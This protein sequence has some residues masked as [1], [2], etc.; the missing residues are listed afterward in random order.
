M[1][2]HS[3][4]IGLLISSVSLLA[5]VSL[6]PAWGRLGHDD[7]PWKRPAPPGRSPELWAFM[8]EYLEAVLERSPGTGLQFG[9]ERYNDRLF[10]ASPEALAAWNARVDGFLARLEGMDR[11]GFSEADRVD[12][13]LHLYEWR[14]GVK[15]RRFHD[16]QMPVSSIDGPHFSLPQM[17]LMLPFRTPKHFADYVSRLEH[18]AGH[19]D[20]QVTQMRL[21]MSAGRTQPRFIVEKSLPVARSLA[22]CPDPRA[23]PFY[24]P[25][26]GRDEDELAVRARSVI[27]DSIT[28]AFARFAGFLEREYAPACRESI[29]AGDGVDG[30]A[31]YD[32]RLRVQ[33]TTDLTAD[34]VHAI[35]LAEVARLRGEMLAVIARTDFPGRDSLSGDELFRAFVESLRTDRRF[36][37][38]TPGALLAHYR[39]ISKRIDGELPK[40]FGVL[41]RNPYGVRE[42]PR[43]AAPT[44]PTAYY[45][46]GSLKSGVAGFFM[47]NTF[48]LDQR[49]MYEAIALTLHEAVPGHHLQTALAQEMEGEHPLR[50]LGGYTA[51]VEGWALYAE[52]LGLEV[53]DAPGG[54]Y[55]DPYDDFGRLNMEM[56]RACRLVVDT[57]MH[58]MGWSRRQAIDFMTA[59]TALSTLNVENEVDRYIGWPGQA[60]AYMIGAMKIRELRRRAEG[61]LRDRFDV[62]AF[63]DAVLGAGALPLPV[64]EVRLNRWIESRRAGP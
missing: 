16:E 28:P 4:R 44:S 29:A 50:N 39:D 10:D 20:Q 13:D 33:T 47:A 55:A 6:A 26:A 62:R 46:P 41:P 11:S 40:L 27:R 57:G 1:N 5:W 17:S 56:W 37:H 63:H 2:V 43:F 31:G 59:N 12:A 32:H 23:S 45:Y 7:P 49:P 9:D 53:G 14:L 35:G 25:F 3:R 51:F 48:A 21:G 52:S 19:L 38:S 30:R 54:L 60:C 8:N 61:A 36:Y 15:G 22:E 58:A 64:L 42:I 24:R 18:V 34:E